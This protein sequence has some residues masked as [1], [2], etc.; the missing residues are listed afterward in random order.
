MI[1]LDEYKDVATNWIA[2]FRKK[3][4]IVSFDSFGVEHIPEKIQEFIGNKNIEPNIF[5]VQANNSVMCDYFCVGFIDFMLAIKNWLILLLYFLLMILIRMTIKSSTVL[6]INEIDK[7][8]LS[9]PT[10]FRLD[11]IKKI[12]TYFHEEINQRK[13][14]SK[15]VNK[16]VTTFNYI[17]KILI[18]LNATTGGICIVSHASVV[19]APVGIASA[20]FT[21]LFSLATGITK[22]Y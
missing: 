7:T 11:E 9:D 13:L 18:V 21:I 1:N 22:N 3:S 19:G 17:D 6:K 2:L 5:W 16:Y 12:E 4:K 20:E 14:C 15:K 10:K 8:K